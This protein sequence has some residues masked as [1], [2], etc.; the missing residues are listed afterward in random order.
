MARE[1][2]PVRWQAPAQAQGA[3]LMAAPLELMPSARRRL[4][5]EAAIA[6]VGV[7]IVQGATTARDWAVTLLR[8]A[9]EV[10]HALL[11]QY[12]YAAA[13]VSKTI[14]PD[15]VNYR[16]KVLDIA[17]QE[18]GHLATVS[19]L[20]LLL[21][22]AAAVHLQRD[23]QRRAS[24]LSAI[25]FTLEAVNKTSLAK[26][27]GA[28]R[29]MEIPDAL[30][31][32]VAE[33]VAIAEQDAGV[34]I[35]RVGVIYELLRFLFSD[36][37]ENAGTE[38]NFADLIPLPAQPRLTD[39]DLQKA[40][41]IE[42]YLATRDEWEIFED[43]ILLFTPRTRVE[44]LAA[45]STVAAQG[46]GL[47][48]EDAKSHFELFMDLV[49]A[50]DKG[51]VQAK[52]VAKSPTLGQHGPEPGTVIDHPYTRLW[53]EAFRLQYTL[54]VLSIQD[55]FR[56]PRPVDGSP[57]VRGGLAQDAVRRMRKVIDD[58][59][60]LLAGL[61]LH[62]TGDAVAGAPYDLD[63]DVLDQPAPGSIPSS[64]LAL[65]DQMELAY[66]AIEASPEFA[67]HPEHRNVLINLRNEDKR[68][69]KL[70]A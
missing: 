37:T 33:L 64:H 60:D 19:N 32:R 2:R 61:P 58:V 52:A 39:D 66:A 10:E 59:G 53:G 1:V 22:G 7:P 38:V 56:S 17:I 29:P 46:E 55:A 16:R 26:F 25:P 48:N 14:A 44:A 20:L 43:E 27:V 12:L 31:V 67:A 50:F 36:P 8:L 63:P 54:V 34:A 4:W 21:G 47:L 69:R 13:S 11:V 45:L 3:G 65:L 9:A 68:H 6:E 23:I 15:G 35:K 5:V 41:D 42:P 49:D 24:D 18:M 40:V 30:K 70:F 28:E 57:G 62:A 51:L